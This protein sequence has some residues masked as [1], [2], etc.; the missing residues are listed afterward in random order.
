MIE[1]L[2]TVKRSKRSKHVKLRLDPVERVINLVVPEKMPLKNAYRFANDHKDW[3]KETLGNLPPKIE[4][5]NGQTLP[6]FGD[7]MMIT[8]LETPNSKRIKISVEEDS[9]IIKTPHDD[10]QNRIKSY[11]KKTARH[12]LAD[13]ANE[14]SEI[15]GKQISSISVRD[16]KSRWGSC[17]SNGAISFSWRL[18]FAPYTA[19]DYVVAHEV[20]HLKHM[21][22]SKEFWETCESLCANCT[23]GK[24]WMKEHG[25]ELMRYG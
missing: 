10:Y 7:D 25:N 19:M 14:K 4:F 9:L 5:T 20:A 6:I 11:L 22:H 23:A 16:T 2:V 17:S 13:L 18:I 24:L 12:G 21:D 1:D 3:V 15:L 8:V